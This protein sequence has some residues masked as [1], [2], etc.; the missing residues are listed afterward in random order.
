MTNSK[1]IKCQISMG[2]KFSDSFCNPLFKK[3]RI[4]VYLKFMK[5]WHGQGNK[6]SVNREQTCI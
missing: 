1:N 2:E 3:C 4:K 5:V 6:K